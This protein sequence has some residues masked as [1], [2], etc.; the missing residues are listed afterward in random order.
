MM[1]APSI[2]IYVT[3]RIPLVCFVMVAVVVAR[4]T[5]FKSFTHLVF[6]WCSIVRVKEIH[7]WGVSYYPSDPQLR[8][9]YWIGDTFEFCARYRYN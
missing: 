9:D 1:L 8:L 6:M 5:L 3:S 7:S 4:L 2:Y